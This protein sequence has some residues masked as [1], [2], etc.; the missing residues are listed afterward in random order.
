M[1]CGK[2]TTPAYSSDS[3]FVAG[4]KK[5]LTPERTEKDRRER[6]VTAPFRTTKRWAYATLSDRRETQ[7]DL[8]LTKK[9]NPASCE[10]GFFGSWDFLLEGVPRAELELARGVDGL[11]DLSEG[12][13]LLLDPD[14]AVHAG[15]S[16]LGR[17]GHVIAGDVEAQR[18]P[19]GDFECLVNG[20]IEITRSAGANVIQIG[21]RGSRCEGVY[22]PTALG[23]RLCK[24]I[25]GKPVVHGVGSTGRRIACHVSPLTEVRR[26]RS[27]V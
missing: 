2:S 1:G 22:C 7:S 23:S 27:R 26:A 25:N 19:F 11:G 18:L 17:V 4:G 13:S 15:I 10:T 9:R 24:A 20:H 12:E 21:W 5:S 14:D 16:V 3:R 8:T 6:R